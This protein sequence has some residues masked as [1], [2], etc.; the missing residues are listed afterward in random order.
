M[1]TSRQRI[2]RLFQG[3]HLGLAF[4]CAACANGGDPAEDMPLR[5][6]DTPGVTTNPNPGATPPPPPNM[7][8][9]SR[10][11]SSSGCASTSFCDEGTCRPRRGELGACEADAQCV[12]GLSCTRGA[13]TSC[14]DGEDVIC[15]ATT[16]VCGPICSDAAPNCGLGQTCARYSAQPSEGV[17]LDDGTPEPPCAGG[18]GDGQLCNAAGVCEAIARPSAAVVSVAVTPTSTEGTTFNYE[19]TTELVVFDEDGQSN[20]DSTVT[21]QD[22]PDDPASSGD[23]GIDWDSPQMNCQVTQIQAEARSVSVPLV[24]DQSGS[25]T[26]TDPS[27]LRIPAAKEF[28]NSLAAA[29]ESALLSF[30]DG[31]Y[32]TEFPVAVY[33]GGFTHDHESFAGTI[34]GFGPCVGG[35]TP[36]YDATR[37]AINL[38]VTEGANAARAVVLFTDGDDTS[39]SA[40]EAQVIDEAVAG[41]VKIFS[42]GL[43]QGVNHAVLANVAQRTSGAYFF[44]ADV[45]SAI[46]AFRGM[47]QLLTGT[48]HRYECTSGL[49]VTVDP[50]RVPGTMTFYMGVDVNGQQ[51]Q[52]PAFVTF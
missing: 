25:I 41:G 6:T 50:G 40:T 47:N 27:N 17:C 12:E 1:T 22:S 10:C 35:G 38:V 7:P 49:S 26:G 8:V 30:A 32:C 16:C 42:I 13:C 2:Q 43:S 28:L 45:G 37:A 44:A 46:S 33:G 24:L 11:T 20:P 18:C 51:I 14:P 52:A 48:Y 39:S 9:E 23:F 29:D 31:N 4:W 19:L 15:Q 36:L 3:T 5:T 21:V 34:D